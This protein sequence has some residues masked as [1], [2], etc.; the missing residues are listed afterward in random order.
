V[1]IA[2]PEDVLTREFPAGGVDEFT[3]NWLSVYSLDAL[4]R[5]LLAWDTVID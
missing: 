5:Q 3:R 1:G 4:R 2:T